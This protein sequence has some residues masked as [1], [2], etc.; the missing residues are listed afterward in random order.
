MVTDLPGAPRVSGWTQWLCRVY[1]RRMGWTVEGNLPRLAKTVVIYAP[2]TSNWDIFFILPA[3]FA[4][5]VRPSFFAKKE[6]F[7]WPLGLIFRV[8]GGIPVD[9]SA[10]GNMVGQSVQAIKESSQIMLGVPPEGTRRKTPYWKSGF[11]HI[12]YNA[13]VPVIFAFTDFKRKIAGFGPTMELTGDMEKDMERIRDFYKNI[14]GK[15]PHLVGEIR[16]K[17]GQS[18]A[19]GNA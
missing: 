14:A 11:Y 4:L 16:F 12:A 6:L 7:W 3:M 2:H 17:P 15:N 8:L 5:G 18:P 10:P 1:M 13:G 19:A 9:R